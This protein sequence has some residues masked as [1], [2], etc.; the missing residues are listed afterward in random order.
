MTTHGLGENTCK[1]CN[2][3]GLIS[4]IYKQLIQLNNRK[5]ELQYQKSK[6]QWGTTSHW[7]EWPSLKSLQIIT[8]VES[9]EKR[10][11]SC[12]VGGNENWCSHYGNSMEVP[13]KTKDRV[14][15][16]SSNPILG[17]ISRQNCNLKRY[18]LSY[19]YNSTI[20]NRQD[21]ETT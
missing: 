8:D 17:Q 19:V 18:M 10:K 6:L 2:Q 4:K 7:S 1:Q 14:A 11:A 9:V 12:T 5:T 13:Q 3:Q 20:Y 15:I 21:I 16:G